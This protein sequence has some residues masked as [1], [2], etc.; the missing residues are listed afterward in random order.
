M[1]HVCVLKDILPLGTYLSIVEVGVEGHLRCPVIEVQ[2]ITF[3][4]AFS[5]RGRVVALALGSKFHLL[6]S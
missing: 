5:F 3:L 1:F 6:M 2:I 4:N